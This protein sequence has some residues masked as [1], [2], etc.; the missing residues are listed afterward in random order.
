MMAS[1]RIGT[2]NVGGIHSPIKR[3]KILIYLKKMQIDVA[4]LQ[5]THLLP[6]EVE[7]LNTMGWKVVASAPYSSKARGVVILIRNS[8][9]F[10]NHQVTPDP[11]GRYVIVDATLD[12]T[13]LILCN[14]Y[15]P[16]TY[17]KE[18]FLQLVNKLY[19][20]GNVPLLMG[21]DFNIVSSPRMD[22]SS[23]QR[24]M[25]R[26]PRVGIPYI[27]KQ[28]RL[29]DSW[30]S[31]H[32]TEKD[33]TCLSAAHGTLSRID[34]LLASETL[35]PRVLEV[36]I[37]PMCVSDHALSWVKIARQVEK[38]T[39]IQ[40][41]FPSHLANSVKFREALA[42]AWTTYAADN[43]A[44][45]QSSPLLFWQAS[46][47]VLRGQILSYTSH[48][49]KRLNAS[50]SETQTKL[51]T[52]YCAFKASPTPTNREKYLSQKLAF[53]TLLSQIESKFTF[54]GRSKFHRH[55][56]RS[57]KL[58]S[59]LLKG[60]NPPTIIKRLRRP[61]GT[62]ATGGKEIS[63]ILHAFYTKL[64]G[65][66]Q[67]DQSSKLDFWNRVTLPQVSPEW[68]ATLIKPI[69]VEEVRVAIKK[70]KCN[71]A[72]GPD[73]LSNEYY[74]ILGPKLLS[75]LA[76]VFN[77]LLDGEQLPLYFNSALLRV[78]HKPGRDP[79]L[80]ASYRP[81][82]L[83]NTDYKIYTKILADRLKP[84]MPTV[85]HEDQTGFIAGRQSVTNVRKVLA[86][87]QWLE[88]HPPSS[89][90]AILSLDAEKAFD[91][92]TWE[93]LFDTLDRFGVPERFTSLLKRLY[94]GASTQILSN[95]FLS[96]PFSI[97]QGTRQGC[98]LSPLLFAMAIEPLAIALRSSNEYKGIVIGEREVKLSMFADDMLLFVSNP[99]ESLRSITQILDQF[100]S[101]AGF[102]VNY[103]KSNLLPLT[104]DVAYFQSDPVLTRFAVTTSPLKYLGIQIPPRLS[105]LY[106]TNL[107]PIIKNIADSLQFWQRLPLSLS[108]RVAVVKSVLFPRLA[109][110]LQMIPLIP[111]KKD[112]NSLHS[113]FSVFLWEGKR[114]RIAHNKLIMPREKGGYGLPD[115]LFYAHSI[116]FRYISDW[117]LRRS[118]YTN[119]MLE[120]SLFA[121]FS[122]SALLHT[123]RH[124]LPGHI[125]SNVLFKGTYNSWGLINRK[126]NRSPTTS[127]YSTFWGNPCFTPSLENP[128]FNFWRDKG[129]SAIRDIFDPGGTIRSF[130]QL[131]ELYDLPHR[132]FYMYLQA[133]H[134]ASSNSPTRVVGDGKDAFSE[135][136]T[137]LKVRPYKIR[138]LYPLLI[139]PLGGKVWEQTAQKWAEDIP[140]VSSPDIWLDCCG[141]ALKHLPSASLQE[142]HLKTLQ[143]AYIAPSRRKHMVPEET[144]RCKKCSVTDAN[145]FHCMWDCGKIKRFWNKVISFINQLF[146]LHLFKCPISCL[147]LNFTGWQLGSLGN[148]IG[149]LLVT[150]LTVARQCIL[151]HWIKKTAPNINELRARML[152]IVYFERQKVYPDIEKGAISFH[153]KWGCYIEKLPQDTQNQIF[154]IFEST[155]WYLARQV[156]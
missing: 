91:L 99:I 60:Q 17:S 147:L 107:P 124:I 151:Y 122:P 83:L 80:P 18:F 78:L 103:S 41:R 11:Q 71:K 113:M 44:S 68:A 36:K 117:F 97:L 125:L 120:M 138:I 47:S 72:P 75:T 153:K 39:N 123:P 53:D 84:I 121:P 148:Q 118:T 77:R 102:R 27:C 150:I 67:I 119:H 33:F 10:I 129:I 134:L 144:G 19:M 152:N 133:R 69:S 34:Y 81:I 65:H 52:A 48:R 16:N 98:P 35:F 31:L 94:L 12:H 23:T 156:V 145:F 92:V 4:Y 96:M 14:L 8:I 66:T 95:A 130:E 29:L 100:S 136:M 28:L 105:S 132:D 21:G 64:Y 7:K 24:T 104:S 58:L 45:E 116:Q 88:Q 2:L 89:P 82:S 135:T 87:M 42:S 139:A 63:E 50:Y 26:R 49:D 149:P 37:E 108:G 25:R 109:Y 56:N 5:E 1:I 9:E 13:R 126:L 51:T 90:T 137:W 76:L 43:A 110:V 38:G 140:E 142:T 57:G 30:R 15:A 127:E 79:E 55:G 154:N 128:R 6:P 46:K 40:W 70:L 143:R 93:H 131:K 3:K 146:S 22:R 155:S 59:A 115:V 62:A 114:P 74:K 111:T 73:G 112:A 86:V 20:V 54:I 61:D 101:F 106:Q 32:P 141:Y 85:I